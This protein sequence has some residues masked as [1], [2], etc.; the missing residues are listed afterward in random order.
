MIRQE[1]W[2]MIKSL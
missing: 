2:V 1:V